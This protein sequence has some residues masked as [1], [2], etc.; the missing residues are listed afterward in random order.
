MNLSL[1]L[2]RTEE[3]NV[4]NQYELAFHHPLKPIQGYEVFDKSIDKET[5]LTSTLVKTNLIWLQ[6]GQSTPQ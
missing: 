3:Q 2:D 1:D 4:P 6:S 5:K